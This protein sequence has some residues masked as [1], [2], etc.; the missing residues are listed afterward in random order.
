M[1]DTKSIRLIS[2]AGDRARTGFDRELRVRS[3]ADF[4]RMFDIIGP[5][6][7]TSY[8]GSRLCHEHWVRDER[9]GIHVGGRIEEML[10][11]VEID[12]TTVR[13]DGETPDDGSCHGTQLTVVRHE[14]E[15]ILLRRVNHRHPVVLVDERPGEFRTIS[16]G[17]PTGLPRVF[18]SDEMI[19]TA[20][21]RNSGEPESATVTFHEVGSE[22]GAE[23]LERADTS[24]VLHDH[25]YGDVRAFLQ[26]Q[27]EQSARE[28]CEYSDRLRKIAGDIDAVLRGENRYIGS[29]FGQPEELA[30]RHR[31]L[32]LALEGL[33]SS[34]S[35]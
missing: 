15:L 26:R 33:A 3:F 24:V 27:R 17:P 13:F 1:T 16:Y 2:H 20:R 7:E 28:L 10:A 8:R 19:T 35:S 32:T 11:D 31:E 21:R 18:S 14:D 12:G 23:L 4:T 9:G 30:R 34:A 25:R 5:E 22:K 6:R 29:A